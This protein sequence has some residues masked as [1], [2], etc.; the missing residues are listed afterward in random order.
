VLQLVLGMPR[1]LRCGL[2]QLLVSTC[3]ALL[4]L[5]ALSTVTAWVLFVPEAEAAADG[6][7]S[8]KVTSAAT[9][10]AIAG[11]DVCA[12]ASTVPF[13]EGCKTTSSTGEYMIAELPA[14][15]YSVS[16]V[17]SQGSGL[18]YIAQTYANSVS[19][20]SGTTTPNIDAALSAGAQLTGKVV[21]EGSNAAIAGIEVCAESVGELEGFFGYCAITNA[22]GQYTLAGLPSGEYK[23]QFFP[24]Y[25]SGLNYV[26]QYY[27]GK[28]NSVEADVL[29]LTA[30]A[31]TSGIDAT[32]APGGEIT[33]RAMSA[34]TKAAISGLEVCAYPAAGGSGNCALTDASGAYTIPGLSTGSYRVQFAVP[35]ESTLN[36]L[37]QYYNGKTT[38]SEADPVPVTVGNVTPNIDATMQPG[39][40]VT[41][42]VT[43]A[44]S[45]SQIANVQV[46][47][48]GTYY[49]CAKTSS[50][51]GYTITALPTGS[52]TVEFFGTGE[53]A[54][55][56]YKERVYS[57]EAQAI[58]VTAG[59]AA[60]SGINAEL[61]LGG[62]LSGTVTS[63]ATS[64]PLEGIT[65]C[66][67]L[68]H[69]EYSWLCT[70][71]NSKGEYSIGGLAATE[72]KLAFSSY[73]SNYLTQ[74]Y[75][76]KGSLAEADPISVGAGEEKSGINAALE[77]G[78][79][80]TG[81]VTS[82]S[83]KTMVAGASV[84]AYAATTGF[85]ITSTTTNAKG[86][87]TLPRLA[88]GT[89][90]VGFDAKNQN[91]VSQYYDQKASNNEATNVAVTTGATTG[92]ID[93][94]LEA[95]GELAGSV[96]DATTKKALSNVSVLISGGGTIYPEYA[97]TDATGKYAI[98]GLRPGTYTVE[99]VA[100]GYEVQYYNG[101]NKLSEATS[102]AV[103]GGSVTEG[104]DAALQSLGSITGTVTDAATHAAVS[105]VTVCSYTESS[106]QT[107]T[108]TNGSGQ[109]TISGLTA[110]NYTIG[111]YPGQ[112]YL[113]QF[114]DG[115]PTLNKATK[116]TVSQGAAVTGID[117][118]LQTG[119]EI[120]GTVTS[121][122]SGLPVANIEVCAEPTNEHLSGNCAATAANGSYVI[123]YLQTDSYRV[124]FS[125]LENSNYLTQFYNGKA[126]L[127]EAGTVAVT[128]GMASEG[129]DASLTEGGQ[130]QGVIKS[131]GTKT[132]LAHAG[133]CA[134][135]SEAEVYRCGYTNSNGEYTIAGLPTAKYIVYFFTTEG[136]Y[137]FQYYDGVTGEAEATLVSVAVGTTTTGVDGSLH[138]PGRITGTVASAA[139][140]K[141][142]AGIE[143]CVFSV[144]EA[145]EDCANTSA[146]G[147]YTV[148][149]AAGEHKVEFRA[150]T[151][152]YEPQWY[153]N[154]TIGS[155]ATIVEVSEEAA[156]NEINAAM[157]TPGEI[158]GRV[159][160]EGGGTGIGG[161]QVCALATHSPYTDRCATT[162]SNGE[163]QLAGL[164]AG[165]YKVQFYAP[166]GLNYIQQYY[167][168]KTS[169][170]EGETVTVSPGTVTGSIDAA[171]QVGGEITG[172]VTAAKSGEEIAG[173][174]VCPSEVTFTGFGGG[175]ATTDAAGKY[176]IE[177]LPTGE[178]RVGFSDPFNS[179]LNYVRQYYNGRAHFSEGQRLAIVAGATTS[180]INVML[181][182]GGEISG[183]VIRIGTKAPLQ[184]ITVCAYE[185]GMTFESVAPCVLTK[186]S[187][188]YTLRGLPP[189]QVDIEFAPGNFEYFTQYYKETSQRS[190]ATGVPVEV[191]HDTTGINAALKSTHPIVPEIVSRPTITGTPQQGAPLT[192]QHGSWTNEPAEYRYQWL[193]C[194]SLGLS[195]LPIKAA[196]NGVYTPVALD[197]GN[198]LEVQ[199]T[200]I[201][202]EGESQPSTSESTGVVVPAKPVNLGP[203][204]IT[205][206]A[207]Q[208]ETFKEGHGSWTNEPTAYTY[209]WERCDTHGEN[210]IFPVSSTEQT[211]K[212][213]SVDVGHTIRVIETAIN[214]GGESAPTISAQSIVV[215][216]EA[217]VS[218]SPPSITGAAV[219]GQVLNESH[220]TWSNEPTG[221]SY[222]WERC[223][224]AATECVVIVE[225]NG[226]SY[227]LTSADVGHKVIVSETASNTGGASKPAVS[228]PTVEVMGAVPVSTVRPTITGFARESAT[229]VES[230]GFWTNEPTAYTYQWKRC[231]STGKECQ[232]IFGATEES[233]VLEAIDVGHELVV[234][235]V[236][237]NGTGPGKGVTSA[238]SE[239]V[240]SEVP[241]GVTSPTIT[242]V[243]RQGETLRETHGNW[244]NE[245][246]SYEMQWQRCDASGE[247]CSTAASGTEDDEYT[248]TAEDL[249][250]TIRVV[251]TAHNAG[252]PGSP[253]GS[254]P[255]AMVVA[256][257]PG[258][259]AP[260]TI[261]GHTVQNETL[262]E[263]HGSWTNEPSSYEYEWERCSAAGGECTPISG[264][265]EQTY[266]LTSTDVGH[267]LIVVE[268]ANNAA[269]S[270]P[271]AASAPT[272]VV[273]PPIPV[274]AGSP[275]IAGSARVGSTLSETQGTWTNNPTSYSY[276][277][278]RCSGLGLGCLP[279]TGAT[280]QT[281]S[282]EAADL[283]STLVV[284]ETASNSAGSGSPAISN[285]VGPVT[286]PPPV[287]TAPPKITGP[288][289]S[290]QTLVIAHGSWTNSPSEYDEQWLRCDIS[291]S[292]CTP[293]HD[294]I[295]LTYAPAAADVGHTLKV[296]EI[297]S[298]PGGQSEPALSV[299]TST[300]TTAPLRANGG[301]N[302]ETTMGVNVT[303]DGNG[304][305]PA[306][307]I[308][309]ARW[310][311]GDGASAEGEITRHAYASPGKYT[312]TLTIE[313]AG[314]S[315]KQSIMVT[316]TPPEHQ[317]TITAL[318][319]AKQPLQGVEVLYISPT[320]VR[321]EATTNAA[322]QVKLSNLPDGADSV[323]L[324]REGYKP[325]VGH[326][327]VSG[328]SG[329][330]TVTLT[331]GP[332][333]E[334]KL[335]SHEMTL[336]EVEAAGIN[337]NEPGNQNVYYFEIELQFG[338]LICHM[339]SNGE[340]V[341]LE[342]CGGGSGGGGG[343]GVTWTVHGGY[344]E[345]VG[346]SGK[347]VNGHPIIET[348]VLQGKVTVLKQFFSAS[349]TISNL[350]PEPF[351]FTHGQATLT[352]PSGM[353][354]APTPT[355]QSQTQNVPD[356]PG[357]GSTEAKWILR[358]DTPGEYY[359]S[360]A[361]HGQLEPFETPIE[362]LAAT[363]E[364]LKVWG[365]EALGFQ[366]QADSG[367][368]QEG[369]PYHVKIGIV[370]KATIPLYNVAI[371]V[372]GSLR[373]H[374][375]YQPDQQFEASVSE[376]KPGE[377]V[378][379]PQ[380]ILVP[381]ANSAGAFEP[382]KSS[383]HFV[384]EE[385]HP[386]KGIEAVAPPPLYSV[387]TS[388]NTRG[389]VHLHWQ[390]SPGAEGYEVFSTPNLDTPFA[391][392][393]D[394]VLT[395]PSS[396]GG[397]T[398]LSASATDAYIHANIAENPRFYA[399][400]TI[401][402]G[403]LR[404][405]HPV[406]EPS[407][408][409]PTGG[410]LTL[411]ELLAGGHNPSEFCVRCFMGKLLAF[412]QPVDAPTGNFWH[413]FTDL[414]IP[415][416]GVALNLTR[417]Y[418]SGAASTGGPFGYGWSFPYGM[419]LSFPDATHVVANQENGSQVTFTEAPDGSYTAA[420]R[421]TATLVHNGD[422]TWTIVRHHRE[423][424]TFDSSG[425]L[426][427]ET[428]LNGYVTSLAY[429]AHGQLE[430][431][432]DPA[433]RKLT[434]TY[435][436]NHIATAIDPLGRVVHYSYDAAGDLSDVTDVGGGD[437]HFAYDAAHRLTSMRTP[438]QA[439]GAPGSTGATV[440]N[441][442][443]SQGRVIEQTDQRGRTTKFAY[444]GEPLSEAG[445][446]T[447]ITDPKG[448]VTV[449]TY[450]FGELMSETRGHGTPEA[451][452]WNFEYDQNTLGVTSVTDPDGHTTNS[453]YDA[454]GNTLTTE[455]AL[456]HQTVNTYDALNDLLTS[457]DPMGVTAAN[458]YDAHGNLL[459]ASRPLTGTSEVQT[460]TYTYG[461]SSH[462]GDVTAMT[463]PDGKT[464]KYTYDAD[465]DR[466]STTDPL[467]NKTTGAYNAI[468]WPT[469][470]TSPRGNVEGAN[471]VSFTTTYA[472]N[473]FGQVTETADP[474][475]HKSANEY[476]PDQNL[477]ASTDA[478]GNVT[479]Y[480]YDAADERTAVHRPDGT[481][482]RTTYW[483]DGTV[484][485]QIDGAGHATGY[486]Y[487]TVGRIIASTDPLGRTTH[488]GHDL[489]GNET[490]MTDP[491]GQVTTKTYDADNELTGVSYSDGKTP[492]VTGIIYNADGERTSMTDGTGTWSWS[493]DSLHRLT[494]ATGGSKGTVGYQYNLDGQLT[495]ITY[496]NG[497]TVTHDYDA[498]G[499]LTGVSDW[500][501]HTTVFGYDANANLNQEQY[502]GGVST[503]LG[504]D[505]A[506]QLASITDSGGG[507]TLASFNYT[508]DPLGQVSSETV[509]NGE[510]STTNYAYDSLNQLAKAN[511]APYGY[512]AADNPTT[513][514][515]GTSQS[516]DAA[517]QLTGR[518]EQGEASELP[519]EGAPEKET[520][521]PPEEP[522]AL[523][524]PGNHSSTTTETPGG[525]VK[526]Y[527]VTYTPPTK[528]ATVHA[529]STS[530]KLTSPVLRTHRS[531]ELLLAF[532]SASGPPSRVQRVIQLSGGGLHW[533][534]LA[535]QALT[536]G[537]AEIWQAHARRAA[538][539]H[540]TARLSTSG[541]PATLT[542]GAYGGSA[543]VNVHTASHGHASAPTIT[544]PGMTGAL[545]VA[546]GN[547]S[548]QKGAIT[549]LP[550]QQLLAKYSS[551]RGAGWVQ[552]LQASTA[553]ARIA[554]THTA[555]QW[556]M[557]A[558][559]I[560]S[561]AAQAT[562]VRGA[563]SAWM[564]PSI[565]LGSPATA[566]AQLSVINAGSR[567]N[568]VS[569]S[570]IHSHTLTSSLTREYTYNQRGDRT[571]ETAGGTA[572]SL[573]Y[574]QANQ[575]IGVGGNISYTY[576]GDGLR[577]S[578]AVKGTTTQFVWSE[579]GELPQLL[580]SGSTYYIYGPEDVPIEQISGETAVY[581][582]QDQQNST[583]L[584]TDSEGNVVGRYT[585]NAWGKV[586]SHAGAT[587]SNLQYDGQYTDA[588]TGYQYLRARY[589]DPSTGQFLTRDPVTSATH[590]PYGFAADNPLAFQ[591]PRGLF[592]WSHALKVAAIVVGV[593][594]I[595][596]AACAVT[597]GA[598]CAAELAVGGASLTV[599]GAAV[600][601]TTTVV[602]YGLD[603]ASTALDCR[604][605][606]SHSTACREDEAGIAL[607]V[608]TGGAGRLLHSVAGD[609]YDLV[610]RALGISY[611]LATVGGTDNPQDG[612]AGD[613]SAC[614]A[615]LSGSSNSTSYLQPTV[616]G[617]S[618]Q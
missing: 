530:G 41:G 78:G 342:S 501:G 276:Q 346:I 540:V 20:T 328:G 434:F 13:A 315:S 482:L 64:L 49:R 231:T 557:V 446:T 333:A 365:A 263:A 367:S 430:T 144:T 287:N 448:H 561:H 76:G 423:S 311:F 492:N 266:V 136:A 352:L 244:T 318:D 424:F 29:H 218:V 441:V 552:Q 255:T 36:Y 207:R 577:I 327:S 194:D 391:A 236:A 314:E 264:A 145:L 519:K 115:K 118:A 39:G 92:G 470:T 196:E 601:T 609:T 55:Q 392:G 219:Q 415:G 294:A 166:K 259:V 550:G 447:T 310:D 505:V 30:G 157:V 137:A 351:K 512:D 10:E 249:G 580:Q 24:P 532:I 278:E 3:T 348:L 453:T 253:V 418:N 554:D 212:L 77:V 27:A 457:T 224:A 324:Y 565:D 84:T 289:E 579:A 304:S 451:A 279:I 597:L 558:V 396:Q 616:S 163:Y 543:Y 390:P 235:E 338:H 71:T 285:P 153:D 201:N 435:S 531:H 44:P 168:G 401:I 335:N 275:K 404:L 514:G 426:A 586:T 468:G 583:R 386:G 551:A 444:N 513:F 85:Y 107:C 232:L 258:S 450:R 245:P 518:S 538:S 102:I 339:N 114:Y 452:T 322:G 241:V 1:K 413:S 428:D 7:I 152:N 68:V 306:S 355:P 349:M 527:H 466:T 300:V 9:K 28:T 456:G 123:S 130:I 180:G 187:G 432:T 63:A 405:E 490:S 43:G 293:I 90:R 521:R 50:S 536:G 319:E 445:G 395:S 528:T 301:E 592:S 431:V 248:L 500:L 563:S 581:L 412:A 502:P 193:S 239:V 209:Q 497:K 273:S 599:T 228:G 516:F 381:D 295:N 517:N 146:N 394:T 309:A 214:A 308:T 200:A 5:F 433:G 570:A 437:M 204:T 438:N 220:G 272:A 173:I 593:V 110:G 587:T 369:V 326:I 252:G 584:L 334:A 226:P 478:N 458:T 52:Y 99:F 19:V 574:D 233:Y 139:S 463:D 397:V 615:P 290:G 176:L 388:V 483:P 79:Q 356:V 269:G 104:V 503:Q 292:S 75:H 578:K 161:I 126:K 18:N 566:N 618:L 541:Y 225:A 523:K 362:L 243:A 82:A 72:Y 237:A 74:Y 508:P 460:T 316:V 594:G 407:I 553:S 504:Y 596:A 277:W 113:S 465:G 54:P 556:G 238:P 613:G 282:V 507:H 347:I 141:V 124:T 284:V 94:S 373:E 368:L 414:S 11:I 559:A 143:V 222:Q 489:A 582:H 178:Y 549:P 472:H 105:G 520:I 515:T 417:T 199:E 12:Y 83:S 206:L 175:C 268:T 169:Y 98:E 529:T 374:F 151:Q 119:G 158:M 57:S 95:G 420:P 66:R 179:S 495:A 366:V 598:A 419:S 185:H 47:V 337:V 409:G 372:N 377:T 134:Y 230:H 575:L 42:T 360:A 167:P 522:L 443:D 370:N 135:T 340:F 183:K 162:G 303:F 479:H 385:I 16:F 48:S 545:I 546:V 281:Y 164:S 267:M 403:Q 509:N 6:G 149:A 254:E 32:L 128:A 227:M 399:V 332:I 34:T 265:I 197:V 380:D 80:I 122:S 170:G 256:A 215:V 421:V 471:P 454:E 408:Q 442:Y 286:L 205:G 40:E 262:T 493:W 25:L 455:D 312:A 250:H 462:P 511:E 429:D 321:N 488:Y 117:A 305:T 542:V 174:E 261:S 494:S 142:L 192:E 35:Y 229:L 140:A 459:R 548:G 498:A 402:G 223:S 37:T 603:A 467:G 203:P 81:T 274:N 26:G 138:A 410:P 422:G 59:S 53:Y 567:P 186:S 38:F 96:I 217:P 617:S 132:P 260:P 600:A 127:S 298:N 296:E 439:P 436:G 547:S 477:I 103:A 202:L 100:S 62:K 45:K 299:A 406:R 606:Q 86:E 526:G 425:R 93:A 416:R 221:Y 307:E 56:Y 73:T 461:D 382:E 189:G 343:G 533:S 125:A 60:A 611:N 573:S 251:E 535:H 111:F 15:S 154:K 387:T 354:L 398:H 156:T 364:P 288:H 190:S 17:P 213:S 590:T 51:G 210:C 608:V 46:C 378:Y 393:P 585:Y 361:Y 510:P 614:S 473:T 246:S 33:G 469:S 544:L 481:T 129:I 188:E 525:G 350:S 177:Q 376:L 610:S 496:P 537:D 375:I 87:Y 485:E 383:A 476:D 571:S 106:T 150:S 486:D 247:H 353:S 121:K 320:A 65:V 302:V 384:G 147:E 341:G 604:N 280:Q 612:S 208:G 159:T 371:N 475:G 198:R 591:D 524:E 607:D 88:T 562:R 216:P 69:E 270:G 379:V 184:N 21:A 165:G 172:K 336:K 576:N 323:Y 572:L 109:Y 480:T 363:N 112:A 464:W 8:G 539:G 400:T 22:S 389:L 344:G 297:A 191:L 14:G 568:T 555:N 449:Q 2:R 160:D 440:T 427:K 70:T 58:S 588:E 331:S 291:G 4:V 499:N 23:V 358:G 61:T 240:V 171:M 155:E 560:A 271:S 325:A 31:T 97:H 181:E 411:R 131:A 91:L 569:E 357:E 313:R 487:D 120:K 359:L 101:K 211:Y 602:G 148:V 133:A 257:A 329:E 234:E 506:D 283:G 605:G 116:L 589:Y 564:L 491:E 108:V 534:L 474:L 67:Y 182:P 595:S 345:G 330:A 484:K 195:C 242:G 89:Y 317:V